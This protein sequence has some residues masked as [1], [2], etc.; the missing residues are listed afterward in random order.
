M[1]SPPHAPRPPAA[2]LAGWA[3]LAAAALLALAGCG[4][5]DR[6]PATRPLQGGAP[7]PTPES[8]ADPRLLLPDLQTT[9]PAEVYVARDPESGARELRFSTTLVNAGEGPLDLVGEPDVEQGTIHTRQRIHRGDDTVHE[10]DSGTFI[11]HSGHAHWHFEDLTM[12]EIWSYDEADGSLDELLVT[13]GK[14]T[15]CALDEALADPEAPDNVAPQFLSCAEGRQG[16]SAGWTDTYGAEIE[17][18]ELDID[19]LPDGRYALH[20]TIDPA[21][22]I[23]EI[24][25][26]NN[27]STVF[28][29]I[30]GEL[31]EL[32]PAP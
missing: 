13:T 5:P 3:A 26:G 29:R 19:S 12:F 4:A 11:F 27:T 20:T 2:R 9:E 31:L 32:L 18:Q 24:D 16:I 21:N 6:P 22:R 25:D 23:Q 17:G 10:R 30:E 15:F 7:A 8:G 28:V 14:A 1:D